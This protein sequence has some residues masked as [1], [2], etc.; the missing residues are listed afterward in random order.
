MGE[1]RETACHAGTIVCDNGCSLCTLNVFF[2]YVSILY[3]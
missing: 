1:Y 3:E 2:N